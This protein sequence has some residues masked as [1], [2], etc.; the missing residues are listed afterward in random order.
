MEDV[1]SEGVSAPREVSKS[2]GSKEGIPQGEDGGCLG[3]VSEPKR[4][5][6][7]F[8]LRPDTGCQNE[9]RQDSHGRGEAA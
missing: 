4:S 5:K 7:H 2:E 3:R 8:R 9:V 6:R 1:Y